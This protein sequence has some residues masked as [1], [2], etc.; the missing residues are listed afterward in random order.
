[1][2]QTAARMSDLPNVPGSSRR[3]PCEEQFFADGQHQ[4]LTTWTANRTNLIVVGIVGVL[5]RLPLII[6]NRPALV[7]DSQSY[8]TLAHQLGA[9]N[10]THYDGERTPGYPLLLLGVHY[11]PTGVW[12]VQAALGI[13]SS[14]LLY[15]IV[16]TIGGSRRAALVA[17]LLF[18]SSI[19]VLDVERHVTTETLDCFLVTA[20]TAVALGLVVS[21]RHR[22]VFAIV[23]GALFTLACLVRPD[24]LSVVVVLTG[25]ILYAWRRE[26]RSGPNPQR[27]SVRS[28]V[29]LGIL[30]LFLPAL[31]LSGWGAVVE[32]A[33]GQR[34]VTTITGMNL[35]DHI[36]PVV[37]PENGPD[38]TLTQL[39]VT[40]RARRERSVRSF[41]DTSW[42]AAPAMLQAT[43]LD[44]PRLSTRLEHIA[45][46]L[47]ARHPFQY[48]WLSAKY[49][50][51]FWLPPNPTFP[52]RII[53]V[54]WALE[55]AIALVLAAIFLA[56]CACAVWLK[57]RRRS[58]P[59]FT[60]TSGL[61]ASVIVAGTLPVI[62]LGDGD[63]GRHGYVFFPLTL[64]A[65]CAG[66]PLVLDVLR[67][68]RIRAARVARPPRPATPD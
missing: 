5:L 20:S 28:Q 33:T 1:M 25:V 58:Q 46:R 7:P 21:D 35:I 39:F 61:V 64:A 14:L 48:L 2:N 17:A 6:T 9:L 36:A 11:S 47:M 10:L 16:I 62:F 34:T 41:F 45:L 4:E 57:A 43:H 15:W 22:R 38:H 8:I 53:R 52:S 51:R 66:W 3:R 30:I 23:L 19:E 55:R 37:A 67:G 44:F 27:H 49:A 65:T 26:Q 31:A 12:C 54:I 13:C 68:V 60:T 18:T 42:A 32:S 59:V 24:A 40:W 50:P 56:M 63:N 29:A